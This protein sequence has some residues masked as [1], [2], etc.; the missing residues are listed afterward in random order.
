MSA[1]DGNPKSDSR[2]FDELR[3]IFRS[4]IHLESV[5][6]WA[7]SEIMDAKSETTPKKVAIMRT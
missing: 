5:M 2:L 1:K 6:S 3:I 4:H 7:K